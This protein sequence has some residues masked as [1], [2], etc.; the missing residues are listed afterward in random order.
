MKRR[1]V[2]ALGLPVLVA[3][4]ATKYAA[5]ARLEPHVPQEIL[6]EL[7]R[8][9]LAYNR[10]AAM[11]MPLGVSRWAFA[12][13]GIVALTVFATI[14][15]RTPPRDTWRTTAL[16]LLLAGALGNLIDRLRWDRGVVDFIDVGLAGWRFWTFNVADSALTI[17]AALL[18][19]L[20]WRR[21]GADR[22]P[23]ARAPDAGPEASP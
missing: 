17:G 9:T 7:L 18:A 11:G 6:G 21:G 10:G 13:I 16:T 2:L 22:E 14:L 19:L 20:L 3:D 12:A 5:V 23:A 4:C 8:F 15:S 1:L